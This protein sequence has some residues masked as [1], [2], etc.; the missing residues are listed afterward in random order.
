[1]TVSSIDMILFDSHPIIEKCTLG[2]K[3]ITKAMID[4][5]SDG[6]GFVDPTT[7]QEICETLG[8][9]PVELV[10][11]RT[12]KGY[13][14]KI[15]PS[16]THAIY[17]RMTIR[18]HTESLAA[19]MITP[20]ANHPVILRRP[21]MM[22]HGVIIDAA[23]EKYGESI[24]KWRKNH[25]D[26]LGAPG[27]PFPDMPTPTLKT[28]EV[29]GTAP[30]S[31]SVRILKRGEK[32]APSERLSASAPP[33]TS[34]GNEKKKRM[35]TESWRKETRK[36][37]INIA[38]I[39]AAPFEVLTRQKGVNIFAVTLQDVT[40]EMEKRKKTVTDPKEVVPEE[41]H[42]F[43]DVFSKQEA[44]KLPPHR[45]YDHSIELL[46]GAE[47]PS[48]APL[49]HMSEQELELIKN[50]LEEHLKKGFIKPSSAP[51]ASSVLFAK[52]PDGGLRFC[53][54]FRKLNEITRKN[55]YSIPLITDLMTRLSKAKYL[56]KIDIRHAFNRIRMITE[57]DEDL[58][59]FRIR[60]ESYKY[61]VLLSGLTNGPATFQNF[62]NDTLMKYLDKFVIAYLDDILIYSKN[63]KE[64]R[65]H[66]RKVLQKLREAGIQADI[67]KCE[68]H[69]L[70][71]KFLGVIVGRDEI[72]MDS[73]KIQAI[74]E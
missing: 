15:G 42:D 36:E 35:M 45:A 4:S 69:K 29:V 55:R 37:T 49:Y 28:S 72:K 14:G 39:A 19:L 64:H 46:D 68:F 52:K 58:T 57:K 5:G 73:K 10:K 50:Y 17:P 9:E 23:A 25:C 53:V 18:Q 7:A 54:D 67:D 2:N 27:R 11:Y 66:V 8:I 26:H 12:A 44:D 74:V 60:F 22:K 31:P 3:Y 16:I 6:Y 41:Y 34:K 24:I 33:K 48:R 21:W 30:T 51:F 61:L 32:L 38:T 47:A 65:E 40:Y 62:M 56:I 13:D 20:L 59:T 63:M 71:T 70:K 1:M 43:L